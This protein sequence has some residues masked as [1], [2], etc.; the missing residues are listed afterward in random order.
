MTSREPAGMSPS[1]SGT[2]TENLPDSGYNTQ[3]TTPSGKVSE[4]AKSN[5]YRR[6][7]ISSLFGKKKKIRLIAKEVDIPTLERFKAIQHDL[8]EFLLG[9]MRAHQK[10]GTR[11]APM[12]I[13]VVMM[14]ISND[15]A[16]PYIV[17]FCESSLKN[18]VQGFIKQDIIASLCQPGDMGVPSFEVVVHGNAPRLR[19]GESDIDV[20]ADTT[21]VYGRNRENTLCGVP[22]SFRL[23]NGQRHHA[24]FGGIIKVMTIS[25]DIELLGMTAGHVLHQWDDIGAVL[26]DGEAPIRDDQSADSIFHEELL[27]HGN[28]VQSS[29]IFEDED[30]D[31]IEVDIEPLIPSQSSAERLDTGS[32]WEFKHTTVLGN[33][34]D[35]TESSKRHSSKQNH[36]WA[37]FRLTTYAM[38]YARTS[39]GRKELRTISQRNPG[40]SGRRPIRMLS[41][42]KGRRKGTLLSEPGRILLE[43]D[44]EF[45]ASFMITISG[46]SGICDGDSGSWVVDDET[47]EVYGQLVAS[48]VLGSG[49]V[50]PMEGIMDDIKSQLGAKTV[51]LPGPTIILCASTIRTAEARHLAKKRPLSPTTGLKGSS[52]TQLSSNLEN[53]DLARL[54]SPAPLSPS[55]S[56]VFDSGYS[57]MG[58]SPSRRRRRISREDKQLEHQR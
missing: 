1:T 42:S 47:F 52:V 51:G 27:V 33:I 32:R 30:D 26:Q 41:G 38:N 58:S 18:L 56:M 25:G 19:L 44:Q 57:S 39:K 4:N 35:V 22:I 20:V 54:F 8:E 29:V 17:V 34:I 11:Y 15:D 7:S 10:P 45:V 6:S 23:P 9:Q 16:R 48:D 49:Y 12:S 40:A 43:G 53:T 46:K 14:G 50:I 2:T 24:T 3:P 37:L 13:R 31:E 28:D 36:D 55:L 21:C 5:W